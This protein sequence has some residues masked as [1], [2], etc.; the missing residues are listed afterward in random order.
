MDFNE[1]DASSITVSGSSVSLEG[2]THSIADIS[3]FGNYADSSHSH[4]TSD[5]TGFDQAA[6]NAGTSVFASSSHTH[7]LSEVVGAVS[8]VFMSLSAYEGL[9]SSVDPNT[10]YFVSDGNGIYK[11]SEL[12]A[13]TNFDELQFNSI[14]ASDI[15][16]NDKSVATEDYVQAQI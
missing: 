2:H 3:D 16:I 14:E 9:G 6:I 8:I 13:A 1:I 12:Y 10:I 4:T 5:I 7:Q 15:K 11:G